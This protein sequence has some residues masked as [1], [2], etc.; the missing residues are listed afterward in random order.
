M[1]V[2]APADSRLEIAHVLAMDLIGYSKLLIDE[3]SRLIGELTQIVRG[4]E[5]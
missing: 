2:E 3:Q 4:T 1:P 5:R